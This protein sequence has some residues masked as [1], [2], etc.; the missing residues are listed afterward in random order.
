MHLVEFN[1][2]NKY[3]DTFRHLFGQTTMRRKHH[4]DKHVG[5]P[6]PETQTNSDNRCSKRQSQTKIVARHAQ[7]RNLKSNITLSQSNA[8]AFEFETCN[9]N[10][11]ICLLKLLQQ[12]S[13]SCCDIHKPSIRQDYRFVSHAIYMQKREI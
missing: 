6:V 1:T 8:I 11:I 9:L 4:V 5:K 10:K 3:S 13:N 2:C 7:G 12:Y